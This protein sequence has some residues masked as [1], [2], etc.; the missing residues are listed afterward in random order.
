MALPAVRRLA[1]GEGDLVRDSLSPARSRHSPRR[2]HRPLGRVELARQHGLRC[3]DDARQ[4]LERADGVDP[5]GVV[6]SAGCVE[7]VDDRVLPRVQSRCVQHRGRDG[8][9]P[10]DPDFVTSS[11]TSSTLDDTTDSDLL[12]RRRTGLQVW[13]WIDEGG[14]GF[15][16]RSRSPVAT[17]VGVTRPL[18]D[19]ASESVIERLVE[20][21]AAQLALAGGVLA[22]ETAQALSGLAS[23]E[24]AVFFG[25]AGHLVHYGPA[26]VGQGAV[27]SLIAVVTD[28][29]RVDDDPRAFEPGDRVVL[30]QGRT[31]AKGGSVLVVR[32]VDEEGTLLLQPDL[33]EDYV[34]R[35]V[36]S[37][38]AR[39]AVHRD[40]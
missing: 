31:D 27:E 4:L 26:T 15:F 34:V 12:R 40:D 33:D 37:A 1:T 14:G 8:A 18:S 25:C 11:N 24:A 19:G 39:L 10:S 6:Q 29:Q 9:Y 21:L 38:A 17:F 35:S 2:L 28:L 23:K 22:D 30:D 36:S 32:H 16:G 5:L 13:E 20:A 3:G 7:G